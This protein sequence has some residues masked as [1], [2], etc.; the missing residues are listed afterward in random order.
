MCAHS[1]LGQ[2]GYIGKFKT[3]L[4]ATD[5]ADFMDKIRLGRA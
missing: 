3:L 5:P 1:D 4:Y 2:L